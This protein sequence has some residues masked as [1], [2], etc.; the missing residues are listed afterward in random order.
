MGVMGVWAGAVWPL[1]SQPEPY[2][3]PLTAITT[4]PITAVCRLRLFRLR[5]R[6]LLMVAATPIMDTDAPITDTM[7][8]TIAKRHSKRLRLPT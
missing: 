8:T 1:V 3:T 2:F 7:A 5:L 4:T 6:S